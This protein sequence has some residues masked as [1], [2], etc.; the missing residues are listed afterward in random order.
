MA[1]MSF[2]NPYP[3]PEDYGERKVETTYGYVHKLKRIVYYS[4]KWQVLI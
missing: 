4:Y 3:F 1:A 2:F